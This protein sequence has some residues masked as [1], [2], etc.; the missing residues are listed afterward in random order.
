MYFLT[1]TGGLY[2]IKKLK[3]IPLFSGLS[4]EHLE[5]ISSISSTLIFDKGEMIFHEGD[6]GDGFYMV[7]KGKIKV[8]KLSYEGKEQILH[9]YGPGHT[10][11]EVP[12]FEGK[13]FPASSMALEK[14]IIIFLPR[15]KF[16]TVI[17]ETPGLGMNLL[18]DLS[19]R[20]REFTIQIENLS[21]KEVPARLAAYIT[22]LSKE[23]ENEKQVI[24]PISKAQLSNLIGTTPETVSR[25][26]KK[27]M[28]SSFIEVKTK[29]IIIKDL[30]GLFELSESGSLS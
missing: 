25:I 23:Q 4:D 20:L 22:T 7:E 16:V 9:I 6:R 29:T 19:R 12:V 26:L 8:F 21:L 17:T 15:D 14:S 13:N 11:G 18:A 1:L 28:S 2:I 27:M 10:F 30:E 5:K 3:T 24:L